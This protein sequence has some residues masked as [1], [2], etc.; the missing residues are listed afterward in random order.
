MDK[1]E[2]TVMLDKHQKYL[3]CRVGGERAVLRGACLGGADLCG[4]RL[5]SAILHD[6]DLHGAVLHGAVLHGAVLHGAKLHGA[7]LHDANLRGACLGGA[8]LRDADLE[9]AD[10][11]GADLRGADLRGAGL[12]A[13]TG[14]RKQ[15]KSLFIFEE[16]PVTYTSEV[17]QIGCRQHPIEDWWGFT[18]DEI[19]DMENRKA[20]PFWN[21]WKGTIKQIIEMSP[22]TPTGA[23]PDVEGA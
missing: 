20:L 17:M 21:K 23:S 15:I 4:A 13:T 16:Y 2:I 10:L 14:N 18:D 3:S 7:K 22:A 9:G 5:D 6:V 8:D 1:D 12:W 11:R 19:K